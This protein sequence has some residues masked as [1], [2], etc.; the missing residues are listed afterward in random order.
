[1]CLGEKN[2]IT[3]L[4]RVRSEDHGART[5][6]GDV[7]HDRDLNRN[8]RLHPWEIALRRGPLVE[9]GCA[10]MEHLHLRIFESQDVGTRTDRVH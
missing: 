2:H 4:R 5:F 6:L 8:L 3:A 7:R 9:S 1:M 10:L